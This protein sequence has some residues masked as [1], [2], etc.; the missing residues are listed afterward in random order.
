M[1]L[2]ALATELSSIASKI[3]GSGEYIT[4][5]DIV[6]LRT[7]KGWTEGVVTFVRI[8]RNGGAEVK[9]TAEGADYKWDSKVQTYDPK[10]MTFVRSGGP[11]ALREMEESRAR[12]EARAGRKDDIAE[13][14]RKALD[15]YKLE[16]G[17][18]V[19]IRYTDGIQTE[20]VVDTNYETGKVGIKK[21]R[22]LTNSEDKTYLSDL[23]FMYRK[24]PV[25]DTRW[26]HAQHVIAVVERF[27]DT[28]KGDKAVPVKVTGEVESSIDSGGYSL[29]GGYVISNSPQGAR[30]LGGKGDVYRD[31]G[32]GLFW[33]EV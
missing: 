30:S 11:N 15:E 3:A 10:I 21:Y 19:R 29:V 13:K 22:G 32:T 26:I 14:G 24:K 1:S 4:E 2:D 6:K 8:K 20:T 16:P 28:F 9:V 12:E 18:K 23:W 25:R 17:D 7:R 27:A 5:G 33:K 31:P